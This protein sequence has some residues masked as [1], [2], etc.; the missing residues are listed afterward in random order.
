ML[1][2]VLS[3]YLLDHEFKKLSGSGARQS[4]NVFFLLDDYADW[5]AQRES[6]IA[7]ILGLC[8][9][10]RD[11]VPHLHVAVIESKYVT[12]A[13][14]AEAKRSSKAQLLATLSTFRE[15]LFGDPGRL[16]RDVW[17]ARLADLLIDAD[18]PPGCSGLL[19]RARAAL[20][21]G[22]ARISLRGYSHVFVHNADASV[23][24]PPASEQ[25]LVDQTDGIQ[26]WQEV[27]ERTELRSL[28]EAYAAK[29]DPVPVRAKLGPEEPWTS[30][31]PRPPAARVAWT[32][33]MDLLASG[34]EQSIEDVPTVAASSAGALQTAQSD[35][36]IQPKP[37][38]GNVQ[39]LPSPT[40]VEPPAV[41]PVMPA[42]AAV[43][44]SLSALI[45]AKQA[46]STEAVTSVKPGRKKPPRSSRRLSMAMAFKRQSLGLA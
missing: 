34:S 25:I 17:L 11:G 42:V 2:L 41:V 36:A 26:A 7:D 35:S 39:Q 24:H 20:R 13:A 15:A 44:P 32:S 19:E 29:G 6:R 21:D 27:F 33:M 8:V 40:P 37:S 23:T 12:S 5:L 14:E 31:M 46:G 4:F 10:E 30:C 38:S 18:I 45:V 16:D 1:G 22:D 43:G 3:R 28:V 9:E